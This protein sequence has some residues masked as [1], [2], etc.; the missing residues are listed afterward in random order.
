MMIFWLVMEM[1]RVDSGGWEVVRDLTLGD[2][3]STPPAGC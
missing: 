3:S 1:D 2:I